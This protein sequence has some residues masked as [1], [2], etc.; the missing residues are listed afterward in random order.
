MSAVAEKSSATTPVATPSPVRG[1]VTVSLTAGPSKKI[2]C[3]CPDTKK[4]RDECVARNGPD[5][6]LELINLHKACL[7]SEG[8]NV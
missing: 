6:C 5:Q 8:F 4:I 1:G 3:A 2:C 7:R